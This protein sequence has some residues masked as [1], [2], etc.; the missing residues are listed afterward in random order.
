MPDTLARLAFRAT[1]S[2]RWRGRDIAGVVTLFL[3]RDEVAVRHESSGEEWA[4]PM[5][6]LS[7]ASWRAGALDLHLTDDVLHLSAGEGLDRAWHAL[8]VRACTLPEVARTL[9]SFARGGA[10]ANG[11]LIVRE[12]F[13]APLL[14]AR[15]RLEGEEPVEWRV[16]GFDAEALAERIRATIAAIALERHEERPPHRRAL[17]AA[18]LDAC[19]PLFAQLAQVHTAART[20]HEAEDA[21]RF[22]A[23]RAWAGEV[24]EVFV[25]A[26]RAWRGVADAL[27]AID[28]RI[29]PTAFR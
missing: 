3:E 11:H 15:R 23:W 17:E 14:Q 19:D 1:S 10:A 8:S 13:F 22:V 28:R 25:R 16:A 20:V 6:A 4:V 24:R 26:D 29:P 12:R 21:V 18:L 9:R 7:G 5:R 2:G 27:A